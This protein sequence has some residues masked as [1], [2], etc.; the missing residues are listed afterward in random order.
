METK[1]AHDDSFDRIIEQAITDARK[2]VGRLC[3]LVAGKTG[4][5][6][7]TLINSVFRGD[8]ARTGSGKP[9]TQKIEEITKPGHPLT[10]IDTKGLEIEDYEKIKNDLEEEILR[11]AASE[12]P[13]EHIHIGWVCIPSVSDRVEDAEINLCKF[14]KEKNIPL[15]VVVTKSKRNDPFIEKVKE[16]IPDADCVLGVRALEEYIEE[17]EVKLPIIG[18]DNL[19]EETSKL[20]PD[21]QSRAYTNALSTRNKRALVEKKKQ[22]E[23][24]VK[25]ATAMAVAAATIP[26]PFSDAVVLLPIQ[27]G[28]LAKIGSTYGM[29]LNTTAITTLISGALGGSAVTLVGR[30]VVSGMLKIIPGIGSVAGGA[31]A[32][33]TAGTLTKLLGD[34]YISVLHAFCESNPGNPIDIAHI[35]KELK[36]RFI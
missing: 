32:A 18:L 12:D 11:R 9:V 7:S 19:I 20:L 25:A 17:A 23:V 33:T 13:N 2:G 30:T 24:E 4:V 16:L 10:I 3:I 8:F 5:G 28:M 34:S 31:I 27:I 15:I 21:A 14:I 26:I 6:K 29:E 35:S 36:R 1:M 22:A